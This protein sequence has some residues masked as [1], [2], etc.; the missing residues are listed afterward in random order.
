MH[1]KVDGERERNGKGNEWEGDYKSI[2]Y[3]NYV[4]FT[5]D[6]FVSRNKAMGKG[7]ICDFHLIIPIKSKQA[8]DD[9]KQY[10]NQINKIE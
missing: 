2:Y 9:E 3:I 4:G 6:L 5:G 7:L 10:N 1:L 8:V